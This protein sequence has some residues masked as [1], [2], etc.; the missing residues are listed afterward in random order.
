MMTRTEKYQALRDELKLSSARLKAQYLSNVTHEL[1]N[2]MK[3]F[4]NLFNEQIHNEIDN[5]IETYA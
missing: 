1:S 4:D 3:L 5:V 2:E